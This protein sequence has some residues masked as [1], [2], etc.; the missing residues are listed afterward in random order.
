MTISISKPLPNILMIKVISKI[1][2]IGFM[3]KVI[4][5]NGIN[6]EILSNYESMLLHN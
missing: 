1:L 5:E 6:I 2:F 3:E 4:Y